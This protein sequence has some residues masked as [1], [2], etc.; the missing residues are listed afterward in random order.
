[1]RTLLLL[2]GSPA[3]GKTTW[4]KNNG[5][6]QYALSADSIRLMCQ[7]PMLLSDGKL[8]ISQSNDKLVWKMLFQLLEARMERGEFT[9]IDAT[10]SKTSST[11]FRHSLLLTIS[12]LGIL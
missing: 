1:M 5:L 3:C 6:E 12:L 8:G 7:N 10:N 4:I 11:N 9:V 2:R